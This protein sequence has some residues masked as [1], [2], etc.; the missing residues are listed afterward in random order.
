MEDWAN[1]LTASGGTFSPIY[2][3]EDTFEY[4]NALTISGDGG[5]SMLGASFVPTAGGKNALQFTNLLMN[6]DY[7]RY[8]EMVVNAKNNDYFG[9]NT[10]DEFIVGIVNGDYA[11]SQ[12]NDDYYYCVLNLPRMDYED[13]F[14]GML[15]V[16][17]YTVNLSRSVEII[18]ELMTNSDLLNILLYGATENY[19]KN[20]EGV[21]SFRVSSDY[22]LDKNHLVGNLQFFAYPCA[23]YGH[24]A[25]YGEYVG[26]HNNDLRDAF[27]DSTWTKYYESIDKD[28]MALVDAIS[29]VYLED[30]LNS[31]SVA[32]F[33]DRLAAIQEEM[34]ATDSADE[35]VK[36]NALAIE[37]LM[38]ED[39]IYFDSINSALSDYRKGT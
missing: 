29:R 8:L 11:L 20:A 13:V 31:D 10:A 16:S 9:N 32:D 1:E 7:C 6:N 34:L 5:F 2:N 35:T 30:L 33:R 39:I 3:S 17:S 12:Q 19:S 36:A 25:N 38:D 21:V 24:T 4:A 27:F 37:K 22:K 15:A 23:D 14:N 18:Q 28:A 26:M